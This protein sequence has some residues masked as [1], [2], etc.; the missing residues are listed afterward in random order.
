M[1]RKMKWDQIVDAA[2]N[3]YQQIIT[4]Y[5]K[6]DCAEMEGLCLSSL[7]GDE[8]QLYEKPEEPDEIRFSND[9]YLEFYVDGRRFWCDTCVS[10]GLTSINRVIK[11]AERW[12]N[13]EHFGEFSDKYVI[14]G[15]RK[16][17]ED[18]EVP[19]CA[20]V[21]WYWGADEDLEPGAEVPSHII[22]ACK[23]WLKDN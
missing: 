20:L 18:Q 19:E 22:N 13:G 5:N 11:T 10:Y 12:K 9:D 17:E 4:A 2:T 3:R 16:R 21:E 1:I 8:S 15:D 6:A 23:K 14:W 7:F